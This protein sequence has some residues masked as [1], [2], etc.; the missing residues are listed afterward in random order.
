[1]PKYVIIENDKRKGFND[2]REK[3]CC[4]TG[5]RPKSFLFGYE[6]DSTDCI[7]LKRQLLSEIERSITD[8]SV[9]TFYVG[10]AIGADFWSAEIVIKLKEKFDVKLIAVIPHKGQEAKWSLVNQRRY[11][12]IL[13]KVDE[14][15]ILNDRYHRWC[16]QQRNN[17]MVDHCAHIIGIYSGT[18]GGTK[19]TLERAQKK[20]LDIVIISPDDLSIVRYAPTKNFTDDF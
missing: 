11:A 5:H 6:E 16:M 13:N 18:P 20:G 1:M 8:K 19:N 3:S 12:D 10:M 4:F 9:D 2:M 7:V 14:Q 17:Y 15:I